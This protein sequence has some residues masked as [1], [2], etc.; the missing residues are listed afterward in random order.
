MFLKGG[1]KDY[2]DKVFKIKNKN[3]PFLNRLSYNDLK[4]GKKINKIIDDYK[5][6]KSELKEIE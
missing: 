2:C 5:T 6:Y 3:N 4:K 1:K